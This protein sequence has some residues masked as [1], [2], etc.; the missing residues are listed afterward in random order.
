MATH[1]GRQNLW[2]KQ[3]SEQR[4]LPSD[5]GIN[6]CGPGRP[7]ILQELCSGPRGKLRLREA[8]V[9]TCPRA[10]KQWLRYACTD[11]ETLM[12]G[13]RHL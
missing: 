13:Q 1:T 5:P 10:S 3:P 11:S 7:A 8:G 2:A 9:D 6:E 4:S 12:L